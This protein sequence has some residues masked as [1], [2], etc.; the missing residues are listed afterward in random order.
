MEEDFV[1]AM[2]DKTK[3]GRLAVLRIKE[4][5]FVKP[6]G[7]GQVVQRTLECSTIQFLNMEAYFS[8][9][10]VFCSG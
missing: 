3:R 1:S 6:R 7:K 9:D 10:R 4:S 5:A 2:H 8:S